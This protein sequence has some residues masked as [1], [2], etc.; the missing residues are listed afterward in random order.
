MVSAG[1]PE[2]FVCAH[3]VIACKRVHYGNLES[4]THV[5]RTRYIRRGDYDAITGSITGGDKIIFFFPALVMFRFYFVW[6]VA[7]FHSLSFI[8]CGHGRFR[9][10]FMNSFKK[11][12]ESYF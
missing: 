9:E 5:K 4:V 1:L 3:S 7:V 6:L 8:F 2:R 11:F 10:Y 12:S